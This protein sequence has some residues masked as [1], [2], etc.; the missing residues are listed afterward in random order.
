M[1]LHS[2]IL[3]ILRFVDHFDMKIYSHAL[4]HLTCF[5]ETYRVIYK[6]NTMSVKC[7]L[8]DGFCQ[9]LTHLPLVPHICVSELG[10]H[11]FR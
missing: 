8:G 11:W 1:V 2:A 6:T 10:Q 4:S 7:M 3:E 9:L 5:V